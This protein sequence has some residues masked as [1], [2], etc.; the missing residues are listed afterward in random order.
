MTKRPLNLRI[1][2]ETI[3]SLKKKAIDMNTTVSDLVVSTMSEQRKFKRDDLNYW[4]GER[5]QTHTPQVKLKI[6]DTLC[7]FLK[8]NNLLEN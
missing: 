5:W 8:E 3:K 2:E 7:L 1:E 4:V 6:L